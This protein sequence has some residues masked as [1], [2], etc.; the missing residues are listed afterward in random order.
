MIMICIIAIHGQQIDSNQVE[1]LNA[2][3]IQ[4]K[5]AK[6]QLFNSPKIKY[7]NIKLSQLTNFL[8]TFDKETAQ[9]AINSLVQAM[10]F[11]STDR[12]VF[13]A[14]C[15][16][17][18]VADFYQ[19]YLNFMKEKDKK[20][21]SLKSCEVKEINESQILFIKT[22]ELKEKKHTVY[23]FLA[24]QDNMFIETIVTNGEYQTSDFEEFSKE[25]FS[26]K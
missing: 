11:V 13:I 6:T 18:T 3:K 1:K 8:D 14:L 10:N 19:F 2:Q 25:I 24:K 4:E 22:Y 20:Q 9:K 15:K 16:E 12:M 7:Y 5:I 17:N 21:T 23:V 26:I